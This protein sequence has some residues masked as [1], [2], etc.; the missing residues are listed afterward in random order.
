MQGIK[1]TTHLKENKNQIATEIKTQW[2][3]LTADWTK[4]RKKLVRWMTG[5]EKLS[6]LSI[7]DRKSWE[8]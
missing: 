3:N 1:M 2:M 6:R 4:Q 5:E 7:G 8:V